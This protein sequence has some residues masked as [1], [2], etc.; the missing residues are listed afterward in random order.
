MTRIRRQAGGSQAAGRFLVDGPVDA[1]AQRRYVETA[2]I[3]NALADGDVLLGAVVRGAHQ[4][5]RVLV[6]SGMVERTAGDRGQRLEGLGRRAQVGDIEGIAGAGQQP[7]LGVNHRQR[8]QMAT[9]HNRA[10]GDF[11]QRDWGGCRFNS[12]SYRGNWYQDVP[13]R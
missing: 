4:R 9:F 11:Y 3:K 2:G 1:A 8:A 6:Q 13:S 12:W 7:T 10:T 5:Q